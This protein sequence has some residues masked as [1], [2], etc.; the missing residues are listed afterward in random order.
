MHGMPCGARSLGAFGS[1]LRLIRVTTT[2][3][4]SLVALALGLGLLNPVAAQNTTNTQAPVVAPESAG[5]KVPQTNAWRMPG[6]TNL[7]R[8][9]ER[10]AVR[11][12][13]VNEPEL[14][15]LPKPGVYEARPY[16]CIV[17]VPG[18]HPDDRCIA[19]RGGAGGAPADPRMIIKPELRL[20]PRG[21]KQVR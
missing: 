13:V 21:T 2:F 12:K 10:S 1:G 14:T 9:P 7:F 19:G 15:E 18:P 5:V 4:A 16:T 3:T 17:V 20:I 11:P 6:R 8:V